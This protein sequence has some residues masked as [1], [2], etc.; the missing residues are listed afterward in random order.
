MQIIVEAAATERIP[1]VTVQPD[2]AAVPAAV[3]GESET[4]AKPVRQQHT[5]AL[6]T[7]QRTITVTRLRRAVA[8]R[9]LDR[10]F[11]GPSL[12]PAPVVERLNPSP[13]TA[14]AAER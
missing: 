12:A 5:P 10:R 9:N 7:P 3:D 2:A 8:G 6:R 4:V 13:A 1:R 14:L 11:F